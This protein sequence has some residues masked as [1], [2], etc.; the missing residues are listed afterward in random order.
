MECDRWRGTGR[1]TA[2]SGP[3]QDTQ[4]AMFEIDISHAFTVI[5]TAG[6]ALFLALTLYDSWRNRS[7]SSRTAEVQLGECG[8]CRLMFLVGPYQR[9]SRCPRCQTVVK[10]T[11]NGT[12]SGSGR[13]R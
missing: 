1:C 4:F 3:A 11:H 2:L 8:R 5:T 7:R 9:V 6:L 10:T 13:K 12:R